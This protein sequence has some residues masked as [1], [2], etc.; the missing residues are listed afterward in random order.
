LADLSQTLNSR[1]GSIG[2]LLNNP[3]LY[4]ELETA[5]GN[6][7]DITRELRPIVNDARVFMDRAA[8]HPG[9]IIRDAISPGSG[10]KGISPALVPTDTCPPTSERF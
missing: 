6:V 7:A 1:E 9:I 2:Q 5:A 8:R 3:H 10:I 4:Q